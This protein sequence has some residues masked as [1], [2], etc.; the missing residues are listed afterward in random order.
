[1]KVTDVPDK[2]GQIYGVFIALGLIAY[3]WLAWLFGAGGPYHKEVAMRFLKTILEPG[4]SID[5]VRGFRQFRGRDAV[6]DALMT[7]YDFILP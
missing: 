6:P 2:E 5:P 3:F 7:K 1:M 4:N